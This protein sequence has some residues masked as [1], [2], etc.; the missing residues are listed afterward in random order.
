MAGIPRPVGDRTVILG[1]ADGARRHGGT[2]WVAC[3]DGVAD[4]E[5][6]LVWLPRWMTMTPVA[7]GEPIVYDDGRMPPVGTALIASPMGN[8]GAAAGTYQI[9][10][11]PVIAAAAS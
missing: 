1:D 3:R 2:E 7:A 9:L 10:T 8:R 4:G 11:I 5:P 6:M